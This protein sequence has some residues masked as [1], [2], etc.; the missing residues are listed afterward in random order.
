MSNNDHGSDVEGG[1]EAGTGAEAI[2][3]EFEPY[4]P[5]VEDEED[6]PLIPMVICESELR[7]EKLKKGL[8]QLVQ[9]KSSFM[10]ITL[11]PQ[12]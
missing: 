10:E 5:N 9:E 2:T 6:P 11:V 3:K 1:T 12:C 8:F 4:D 7:A